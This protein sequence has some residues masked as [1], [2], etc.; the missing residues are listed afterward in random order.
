MKLTCKPC[1]NFQ[2]IEFEYEVKSQD[3]FDEMTALYNQCLEM[4][5]EIAPEQSKQPQI[6]PKAFQ[7]SKDLATDGQLSYMRGLGIKIPKGCTKKQAWVLIKEAKEKQPE[8]SEEEFL[9]D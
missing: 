4:L 1:Y 7:M 5:Q 3:D 6:K 2:T 9:N 8:V